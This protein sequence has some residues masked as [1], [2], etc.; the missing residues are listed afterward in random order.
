M[1]GFDPDLYQQLYAAATDM[2]NRGFNREDLESELLKLNDDII[3]VT[4]AMTEARKDYYDL[5]RREGFRLISIGCTLAMLGFLI[6]C[7]NFDTARS[8][9]FAMYGLTSIGMIIVFWG[10]YKILG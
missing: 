3:I 9:Y 10:L 7:L 4:V 5:M 2:L 8:F 6:T 1:K